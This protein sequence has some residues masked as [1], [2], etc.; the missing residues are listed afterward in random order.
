M[1]RNA[2]F[3]FNLEC[4]VTLAACAVL[5]TQGIAAERSLETQAN[6]TVEVQFTASRTYADPFHE[7][8]LDVVFTDPAG[9]ELRVPAFWAGKNEWKVR[10][11]SPVVGEHSFRSAFPDALDTG[12]HGITGKVAVK[13]YTGDNPLYAH[14]P[15]RISAN[16]RY[17][18]H[19]DGTPFFW[20]GDTWWMGLCHRLKFPDEFQTLAADRKKKGFNVIQLVAGLYPDM[21]PFDPRG[22]NEAGFPWE[23]DYRR[24]RPEYFDAVDKRLAYLVEQGFT[25]CIGGA[26][27]Y[28]VKFMGVE[29][30]KQH[31]RY[32][33]ARYGASP[34]VWCVAGEAN[35]PYYQVKGFPYD[36]REQVKG[37]TEV[38]RYLR[39][40]DPFHRPITIH[41]T[42]IG[43]LSARNAINDLSLI[44]FDMLQTPHGEREA[45]PPT[46][47]TVRESYA[48]QP[49]LPVINGE[50]AYEMLNGKI[51]AEWVRAMFWVCMMNGAAG[52]TY[53]AN[54]IW[55]CNRK[56]QPHGP[57][58]TAG[59]PPTGYGTISWD[60]A[61]NLPGSQQI[62]FG[63]KLL[64]EFPWQRFTP[65]P[66][67][68]AFAKSSFLAFE[69]AKWIW[70]PE[71]EPGRDAPT[72]RR[73]FRKTFVIPDGR[74]VESARLRISA[75]DKFTPHINGELLGSSADW[76]TGAQFNDLARLLKPGENVIAIV[77]ENVAAKVPANPAGMIA[78]CEV[79]FTGGETVRLHSDATWRVSKADA[80][81]WNKGG[82][83]DSAWEKA[84][85]IGEY[86][87]AP[88]GQI[89]TGGKEVVGPQSA[90]IPDGVRIIYVPQSDPIVVRHLG[91]RAAFTATYFDTVTGLR[92]PLPPISADDAGSWECPPP[93]GAAHDWV[94]ILVPQA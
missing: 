94:V 5:A 49:V 17:L 70:F 23:E 52:H 7:V 8:T 40:L 9:K 45:V 31:W 26:W 65:H 25:P 50:A 61:M 15:L 43:R 38:T 72:E 51:P 16:R 75:D 69:G 59:S 35:L 32:L 47:R 56:G 18:E 27:G 88:W 60:E 42:G 44:D 21:P 92:A 90:G 80:P 79:R 77:G 74:V 53:G 62:G 81:G 83:N 93:A 48:D 57:S 30:S 2:S 34:V 1:K 71:G 84:V 37:W 12:L 82:F 58:P 19:T 78:T 28:F 63:K 86:G 91:A 66:E 3:L 67:W 14:G 89:G 29:K 85:A 11:A 41:P 36:D 39:E 6:V 46:V 68:A 64:A 33:V 13:P 10:Y 87:V 55:Q 54:G 22:A 20:L 76:K 24:I 73:F 4:F